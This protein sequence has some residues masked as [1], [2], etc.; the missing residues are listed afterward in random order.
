[1]KYCFI[2][3]SL[4][5]SS[6]LSAQYDTVYK[7]WGDFLTRFYSERAQIGKSSITIEDKLAA[8]YYF[9]NPTVLI[10]ILNNSISKDS[11]TN[12]KKYFHFKDGKLNGPSYTICDNNIWLDSGNYVNGKVD[13]LYKTW[14]RPPN[15]WCWENNYKL[16][17]LNGETKHWINEGILDNK[18]HYVD[19]KKNGTTTYFYDNGQKAYE[20]IYKNDTVINQTKWNGLGEKIEPNNYSFEK[21]Y[22][23]KVYKM[24]TYRHH[25]PS[26]GPMYLYENPK[27]KNPARFYP[28]DTNFISLMNIVSS[29]WLNLGILKLDQEFVLLDTRGNWCQIKGEFTDLNSQLRRKDVRTLWIKKDNL[30]SCGKEK[31][32]GLSWD[33]LLIG[34]SVHVNDIKSNPILIS[35]EDGSSEA[36]FHYSD[37]LHLVVVETKGNWAKVEVAA[38]DYI[39]RPGDNPIIGKTGWI[40]WKDEKQFLIR[41]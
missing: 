13:G 5:L 8:D 12:W 28:T 2:L 15:R 16:G 23:I 30:Y 24:R 40:R 22:G 35:P 7:K 36:S 4:F 19:G 3:V 17:L 27:D 41:F 10:F 14:G 26:C 21:N 32:N 39:G 33:E 9:E 25:D 6:I 18:V 34:Q 37:G 20:L 31:N 1:M 38:W 11:L 29:D